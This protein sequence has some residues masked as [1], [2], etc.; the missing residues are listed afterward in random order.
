M[1]FIQSVNA[2]DSDPWYDAQTFDL[3]CVLAAG[4]KPDAFACQMTQQA[5][6]HACRA[7]L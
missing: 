4:L 3:L 6:S 7:K 2:E 1:L 5:F